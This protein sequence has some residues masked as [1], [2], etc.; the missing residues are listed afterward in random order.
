MTFAEDEVNER[1]NKAFTDR[2]NRMKKKYE[3]FDEIKSEL[4]EVQWLWNP[5]DHPFAGECML[6]VRIEDDLY[7]L[8]YGNKEQLKQLE[9]HL[10]K[11]I[12]LITVA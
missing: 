2:L 11:E 5:Y 4:E 12:G 8:E 10:R 1:I 9:Q 7:Q 6:F 3:C